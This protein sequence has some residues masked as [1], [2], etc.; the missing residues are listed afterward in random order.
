MMPNMPETNLSGVDLNLLV[1]LEALLDEA[2]VGRAARRIGLSQPATSQALARLRALFKDQLLARSGASMAR[3]PLA[4]SL[5]APVRTALDA[6][7]GLF[8]ER[9]FNS[10]TST[11]TFNIMAPDVIV[12]TIA[13]LLIG[14]LADT[15]PGVT[16]HFSPWRGPALLTSYD[17]DV[18][19][20]II[21]SEH[22][23]FSGFLVEPLYRDSD[24]IAVR[25]DHPARRRLSNRQGFLSQRHVAVVGAGETEDVSE[26]WL[27]SVGL[28]RTI[29]A[30]VPTYLLALRLAAKTDLVVLTPKRLAASMMGSLDLALS[31]PP[32][33]SDPD[34]IQ[35]LASTRRS[36]DPAHLWMQDHLLR[37]GRSALR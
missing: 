25:A 33:A 15:A 34:T 29:G 18:L 30:R 26:P 27:R 24:V 22:A 36:T 17:L 8:A 2:H 32:V 10:S 1:A 35:L 14:V 12:D 13:P 20:F 28:N 21:T 5:V 7:R 4:Q 16:V 31:S 6:V 37:L 23:R 3:T 9:R 19:D 11:R